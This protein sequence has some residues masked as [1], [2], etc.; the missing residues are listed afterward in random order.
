VRPAWAARWPLRLAHGL[1]APLLLVPLAALLAWGWLDV[2]YGPRALLLDA[3]AWLPVSAGI[4][5]A[6]RRAWQAWLAMGL[7]AAG[8]LLAHALKLAMMGVPIVVAD[9]GNGIELLRILP[10]WRLVI[11]C[12]AVLAWLGA[13]FAA[14]LP[15]PGR[16]AWLLL[17]LAWAALVAVQSPT[18]A[19]GLAPAGDGVEPTRAQRLASE[20]GVLY[21]LRDGVARRE[22]SRRTPGLE[23]VEAALE[24]LHLAPVDP[25]PAPHFVPRNVH[26]VLLES[27]WDVTA[28][29]AY[30]FSDDPFDPRFRALWEAG[31]SSRMLTPTFG[32]ATANAEFELLCAMPAVR[33]AV[34]FEVALRRPVPCLPRLLREAGYHTVAVHPFEAD[35]WSRDSAYELLGFESYR[36]REAFELDDLDGSYLYD[37]STYSQ[38]RRWLGA[39]GDGRPRFNYVVGLSTHYPYHRDAT[40]R[41]DR[42]RVEPA[43]PMLQDYANAVRYATEAF[44]DHA[45]AI[46]AEDPD[47]LVIAFGDHAPVLG[48]QPDPYRVSG[49]DLRA[50]AES[51]D[52]TFAKVAG[53]P[54][55]VI[56]G[57]QG[58]VSLGEVPMHR[59]APRLLALLGPGAPTLPQARTESPE[60]SNSVRARLYLSNL[61]VQEE[62]GRWRV[63]RSSEQDGQC[64]EAAERRRHFATLRDDLVQGEQFALRLLDA[65]AL[66]EP[67]AM[68]IDAE[69]PSCQFDVEDWGPRFAR[70]GDG[71]NVQPNGGSTFWIKLRSPARGKHRLHV[72][73]NESGVLVAGLLASANVGDPA[74]LDRPGTYQ[75]AWSCGEGAG[76]TLGGFTVTPAQ[77]AP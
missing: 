7:L 5:L 9:A 1:A 76:G 70:A 46:L 71:F 53:T 73:G 65:T 18:I 59:L 64:R 66:G 69:F 22:Q 75:L 14:F 20:G 36:A 26:L 25:A 30:R 58:P 10:G 33:D 23:E 37:G 17:P 41:P 34:V 4:A 60:D 56:N 29:E 51:V 61:M 77:G 12:L 68:K 47:A 72:D 11:A 28:L 32:G 15:A 45:G 2:V 24:A 40:R 35:F 67:T 3:I 16:A 31:G 62:T 50:A 52:E 63:C 44:M 54:L 57:R 48:V 43:A 13:L 42:V 38:F 55:L 19:A 27:V 74:W 6:A 8:L 39:S 49:L 21:L